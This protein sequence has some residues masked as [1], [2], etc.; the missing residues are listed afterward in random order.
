MRGPVSGLGRRA[1]GEVR[2]IVEFFL[3]KMKKIYY[4]YLESQRMTAI[5]IILIAWCLCLAIPQTA[6]S[7]TLEEKRAFEADEYRRQGYFAQQRGDFEQAL[8]CFAKAISLGASSAPLFNDTGVVYEQM[9]LTDRAEFFYLKALE[10]DPSYLAPYTNLA[11][12]YD[13]KG[14]TVQ[15]IYYFQQR[16]ERSNPD[17]PWVKKIEAEL[18]R[19]DPNYR[20]KVMIG[21]LDEMHVQLEETER[22][23]LKIQ[24]ERIQRHL[25]EGQRLLEAGQLN[26][27]LQECHRAMRI[28]PQHPRVLEL[29][30]RIDYQKNIEEIATKTQKAL[31][32]LNAG[33]VAAAKK[34]YQDI[35]S[36]IPDR[37]VPDSD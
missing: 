5:R 1:F 7:E 33:D 19:I 9:G 21:Q 29:K 34:E 2:G 18:R 25:D 3:E 26:E 10:A 37:P 30:K 17:D 13:L 27:A 20:K 31:A 8:T 23:E 12:L 6:F 15:A 11:Y 36:I 22:H 35:L 24:V 4:S 32:L 16:I 28:S 14:D